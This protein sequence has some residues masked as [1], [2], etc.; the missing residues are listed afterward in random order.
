MVQAPAGDRPILRAVLDQAGVAGEPLTER[1]LAGGENSVVLAVR[2]LGSPELVV[3]LYSHELAWKREK[4]VYI[5]GLLGAVPEVPVPSVLASG[6]VDG[7]TP[8]SFLVLSKIAGEIAAGVL[9]RLAASGVEPV[10]EEIGRVLRRIHSV[11]FESFG[12]L[13]TSV[14]D[15][16]PSNVSYMDFQFDKKLR[17]FDE[18]QGPGAVRARIERFLGGAEGVFTRCEQAVLCHDDSHEGNVLLTERRG[19]WHVS[20]IVDVENAVSADPL[21]DLAKTDYYAVRGDGDKRRGLFTGYGPL[22]AGWEDALSVY[23]VYHALELWDWFAMN[24]DTERA[25]SVLS[26]LERL[27]S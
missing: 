15:P 21:L 17:E 7:E 1:Q 13:H 19:G 26:D 16:H 27:T 18:L 24:G 8:T 6:A 11:T 4:E 25:A 3:K 2:V 23:V 10:Y 5:Y 9:P 14:L 22:P 20:G 12:Y